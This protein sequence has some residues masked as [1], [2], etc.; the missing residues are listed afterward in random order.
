MLDKKIA[1]LK[2]DHSSGAREI[3]RKAASIL[4]E[5]QSPDIIEAV[6]D[7]HPDMAPLHHLC[8]RAANARN[9]IEEIKILLK[10]IDK[11][12]EIIAEELS[13]LLPKTL[14]IMTYSRSSTV[15]ESLIALKKMGCMI[16]MIVPESRPGMEGQA[17]SRNLGAAG[18]PTVLMTDAAALSKINHVDCLI[19]GA[20]R[21]TPPIFVNKIGTRV[22]AQEARHCDLPIYLLYDRSKYAKDWKYPT[23]LKTHDVSEVCNEIMPGVQIDNPYFEEIPLHLITRT[24]T[25]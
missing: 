20:D 5:S 11:A 15:E 3:L 1:E 10:E 9:P 16:Q 13:L 25:N 17:L 18:I 23:D 19:I 21:V 8:E 4:S 12:P 6:K 24:I 14:K 2:R 7:T 22:F